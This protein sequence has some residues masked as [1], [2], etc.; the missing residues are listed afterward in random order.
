[1]LALPLP[2]AADTLA[3]PSSQAKLLTS[4]IALAPAK[5]A[6]VKASLAAFRSLVECGKPIP[7]STKRKFT[8]YCE[9]FGKV[10]AR[11]WFPVLLQ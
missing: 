4:P 10:S 8:E 9:F 2:C 7:G 6:R 5:R 3:S 11:L 1:M